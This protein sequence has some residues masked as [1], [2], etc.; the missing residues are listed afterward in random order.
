MADLSDKNASQTVKPGALSVLAGDAQ[1]ILPT[2]ATPLG[3]VGT[4]TF[5]TTAPLSFPGNGSL[6][7][8]TTNIPTVY[9]Q[10]ISPSDGNGT[11]GA[12][13]VSITYYDEDYNGPYTETLSNF[14]PGGGIPL[15]ASY[16]AF[17]STNICHILKFEV[18]AV[19]SSGTNQGS[20]VLVD[21]NTSALATPIGG[22]IDAGHNFWHS[23]SHIVPT[24]KIALLNGIS[25]ASTDSA[26][27]Q[28]GIVDIRYRPRDQ[29]MYTT[30]SCKYACAYGGQTI[31]LKTPLKFVG[32]GIILGYVTDASAAVAF[33]DSLFNIIEVDA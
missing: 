25:V 11:I 1:C 14:A 23:G 22:R 12:E 18:T 16:T 21:D 17:S 8:F 3:K 20:L 4:S 5:V 2:S 31:K 29:A 9:L 30:F 10:C 26:S 28:G 15:T 19:G 27:G 7:L 13:T 32:P 33:K 24:G 6:L